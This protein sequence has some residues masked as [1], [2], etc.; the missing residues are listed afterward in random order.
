MTNYERINQIKEAM[1]L[2]EE[3]RYLVADAL[4][5]THVEVN[6]KAYGEYGFSQLLG[7]GNPYAGSIPK[8]IEEFEEQIKIEEEE[9]SADDA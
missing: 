6:Y 9:R 7:E 2:V 5:W 3:A 4:R 1:E 8:L